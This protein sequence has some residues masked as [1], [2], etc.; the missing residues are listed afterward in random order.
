MMHFHGPDELNVAGV[1]YKLVVCSKLPL[2]TMFVVMATRFANT[3]NSVHA[4]TQSYR[5]TKKQYV[6]VMDKYY[7]SRTY[8]VVAGI[9]NFFSRSAAAREKAS[10]NH[11]FT[12]YYYL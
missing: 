1:G 2:V 12:F 5:F 11:S 4:G 7:T 8:F 10:K 6:L 3:F 9:S